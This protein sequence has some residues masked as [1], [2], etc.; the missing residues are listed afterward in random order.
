M[1]IIEM[2]LFEGRN[3][4]SHSPVLQARLLLSPKEQLTTREI[5]GFAERL[6]SMLPGLAE[7][8]C[9]LGYPGGFCERL[10]EG[11]YLG[12]VV[13]HVALELQAA[14]GYPRNY[15][16]TVSGPVPGSWDVIIEYST[17]ELGRAALEAAVA[18]VSAVIEGRP[19]PVAEVI[20]G[21]MAVGRESCLGPSTESIVAACRRR[22]IP[23]M[24]VAESGILQLGYG[25]RQKL[26]QATLTSE[27]SC[28]AVDLVADKAL[29]KRILADA[30]IPVPPGRVVATLQ[31]A[32]RAALEL[33]YPVAVKPCRGNQGKG[34]VLGVKGA[35]ELAAA[36]RI[37]KE[38]G[39]EVLV[40]K[41]VPGRHYRLLVIGGKLVA[42]A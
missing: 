32:R 8:T 20:S 30:G 23:V 29:T 3:V 7:H 39:S 5:P 18:L 38:H 10:E 15:G 11:T 14:A 12:H 2:R 34:V 37:A 16:K 25:C 6:R 31:E 9:G 27:T 4:W 41:Q 21:L 17:P 42:A 35:A 40:E 22:G 26:V 13:E 28:L 1:K 33:G 36:F 24:A 19:F